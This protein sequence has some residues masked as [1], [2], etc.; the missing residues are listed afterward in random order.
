MTSLANNNDH[1]V[2]LSV[3]DSTTLSFGTPRKS[4][5]GTYIN[6]ARVL[7]DGKTVPLVIKSPIDEKTED[8]VKTWSFTSK[9]VTMSMFGNHQMLF[10]LHSRD[11]VLPF[12]EQWETDYDTKVLH[13]IATAILP[14]LK[15]LRPA[16]EATP[17]VPA[18]KDEN[19]KKVPAVPAKEGR[20]EQ[21]IENILTEKFGGLVPPKEEKYGMSFSC[22]LFER[23]NPDFPKNP[24]K[25]IIAP[26][27]YYI[28]STGQEVKMLKLPQGMFNAKFEIRIESVFIN[29][30][31][32]IAP[33]LICFLNK[34]V[35]VPVTKTIV[36]GI[37]AGECEPSAGKATRKYNFNIQE[38][39]DIVCD[40]VS[41][42][43]GSAV[44]EEEKKSP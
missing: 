16:I 10:S 41:V 23:E 25:N 14:I 22:P 27:F 37:V 28:S 9:G 24:T 4:K 40:D 30:N 5:N 18:H 7:P 1:P 2:D 35:V 36:D 15:T 17:A 26:I 43:A 11:G 39:T 3:F 38:E 8:D 29:S 21:T 34:V 19:G 31:A 44:S 33:K 32:T 12:Q 6:I 42:S 13:P 20:P